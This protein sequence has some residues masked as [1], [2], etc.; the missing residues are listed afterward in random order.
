MSRE[1]FLG[2]GMVRVKPCGEPFDDDAEQVAPVDKF[3]KDKEPQFGI[4]GPDKIDRIELRTASFSTTE[5]IRVGDSPDRLRDLYGRELKDVR[6]FVPDYYSSLHLLEGPKTDLVFEV[7]RVEKNEDE[8]VPL[9]EDEFKIGVI[10]LEGS[11]QKHARHQ[12]E[13]LRPVGWTFALMVGT[14]G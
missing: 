4:D 8:W 2:T 13:R 5:C 14:L 7:I 3:V 6:L 1:E 10:R 12:H 9:P 11:D